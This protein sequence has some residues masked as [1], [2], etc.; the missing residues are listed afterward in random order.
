MGQDQDPKDTEGHK[1]LPYPATPED[2]A[3]GHYHKKVADDDA[4]ADTEGHY[5]KKFSDDDSDTEGHYH[6]K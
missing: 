3:E 6:K 4:N 1:H 5:H 2:D